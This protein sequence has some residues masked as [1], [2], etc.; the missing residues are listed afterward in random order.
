MSRLTKRRRHSR[1][2]VQ[3]AIPTS[4]DRLAQL[5]Q[6]QTIL[7]DWYER[8]QNLE[9]QLQTLLDQSKKA[10]KLVQQERAKVENQKKK[11]QQLN[12][13]VQE[14]SDKT[15]KQ[16]RQRVE[17]CPEMFPDVHTVTTITKVT[18][19]LSTA[20]EAAR[21]VQAIQERASV[22]AGTA[23]DVS[24]P[25]ASDS[26]I[27]GRLEA[28]LTLTLKAENWTRPID[29]LLQAGLVFGIQQWK[30]VRRYAKLSLKD[31]RVYLHSLKNQTLICRPP[32]AV[33]VQVDEIVPAAPP[34]LVFLDLT[35]PSSAPR[36]VLIQL[37][38]NTPR[39][40]QF[41]LLCTGQQD[42]CYANTKLWDVRKKGLP[43]ENVCGGD[44]ESNNGM[45]GR[46]VLKIPARG[47]VKYQKSGR[48]GAVWGVWREEYFSTMGAQ[49]S[50]TTKDGET[51]LGVFGE[52]VAGLE[53]VVAATQHTPITEVTV[54]DCGVVLRPSL[55]G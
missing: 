2:E 31:S 49:F 14:S 18:A 32:G 44:Y 22:P 46:A 9:N 4:Q 3:S 24:S 42:H 25:T 17:V 36:R 47:K 20:L 39:G 35:W 52:V 13:M 16:E 41:L 27:T 21:T 5:E 11:E 26:S 37:D 7:K 50:I 34:C 55:W 29:S 23:G 19:A 43:G 33:T 51:V 54:E 48:A 30:G 53:V 40:R 28:Q 1:E 10:S 45:G 6:Y 38:P 8:Q 15:T 12:A